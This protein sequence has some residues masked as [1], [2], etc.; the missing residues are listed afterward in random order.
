MKPENWLFGHYSAKFIA[1][2][3]GIY[4]YMSEA[5]DGGDTDDGGS[6][7]SDKKKMTKQE[8][9]ITK[10]R[11]VKLSAKIV[12]ILCIEKAQKPELQHHNLP[13]LF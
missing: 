2:I 3:Y 11:M 8:V 5:C 13:C 9:I 4:V 12:Q 7:D 10:K 1:Q 6:D